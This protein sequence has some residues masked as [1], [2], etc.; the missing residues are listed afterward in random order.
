MASDSSL[1]GAA[2]EHY[3]MSQLLRLGYIAAL[4]PQ[5]VPNADI[6]V[7]DLE[8]NKTCSIQV[9]TKREVGIDGG[10]HM[11]PKH[12]T[13]IAGNLFYCFVNFGIS[14]ISEPKVFVLPS[15]KVAEVIATSHANW[16]ST[17]GK[18][19]QKRNDSDVRRLLPDYSNSFLGSVNPYPLGWLD[20]YSEAWHLLKLNPVDAT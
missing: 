7:S 9:K 14:I 1:L 5:G 18:R 20:K 2:G 6:L 19:G 13:L 4:A 17:P 15:A 16:L 8:G 10:W 3:V 12:E 11:K